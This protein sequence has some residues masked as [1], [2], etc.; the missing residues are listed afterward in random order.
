M[1][2]IGDTSV[3]LSSQV[4]G[5]FSS[6]KIDAR[7]EKDTNKHVLRAI[8]TTSHFPHRTVRAPRQLLTVRAE[9]SSPILVLSP[10]ARRRVQGQME[11]RLEAI[12]RNNGASKPLVA[13]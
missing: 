11:Q 8:Q 5:K 9:V 6:P 1:R 10:V 3:C 13:A 4:N 7:T 2:A 12:D